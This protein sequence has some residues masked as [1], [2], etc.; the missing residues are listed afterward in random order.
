VAFAADNVRR[1]PPERRQTKPSPIRIPSAPGA[2]PRF[3]TFF[4]I[5]KNWKEIG[6]WPANFTDRNPPQEAHPALV[7]TVVDP[8]VPPAVIPHRVCK[9]GAMVRQDGWSVEHMVWSAFR[10]IA[11]LA[12]AQRGPPQSVS[13]RHPYEHKKG[14]PNTK[15]RERREPPCVRRFQQCRRQWLSGRHFGTLESN[16]FRCDQAG[17]QQE[18]APRERGRLCPPAGCSSARHRCQVLTSGV[19]GRTI[20]CRLLVWIEIH[21]TASRW[22]MGRGR[23]PEVSPHSPQKHATQVSIRKPGPRE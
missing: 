13:R 10:S 19:V 8:P 2:P 6:V 12:T 9:K 21:T 5:T 14:H 11:W 18:M 15:G 16:P 17:S 23:T 1:S 22:W 3:P 7:D 4:R 20:V